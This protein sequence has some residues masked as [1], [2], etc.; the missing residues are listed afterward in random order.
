MFKFEAGCPQKLLCFCIGVL[1]HSGLKIEGEGGQVVLRYLL[2]ID[3]LLGLDQ[4][5]DVLLVQG[6][7][8]HEVGQKFNV[9]LDHLE[10][11]C[12]GLDQ[13]VVGRLQSGNFAFYLGADPHNHVDFG[14][15][16][17]EFLVELGV[18]G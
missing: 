15:C 5:P 16:A 11:H 1:D 6:V 4:S 10:V 8:A 17:C 7:L 18:V 9:E 3:V 14:V 13:L 12:F 2:K